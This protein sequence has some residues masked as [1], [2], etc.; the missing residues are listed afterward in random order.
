VT[1]CLL[2][3]G[4]FLTT[5]ALESPAFALMSLFPIKRQVHNVDPEN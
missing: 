3:L 2:G 1:P 5:I 4:E